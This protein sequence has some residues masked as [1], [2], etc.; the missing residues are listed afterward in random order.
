M[1]LWVVVKR[2][3]DG[4]EEV[5]SSEFRTSTHAREFAERQSVKELGTEFSVQRLV[6]E[7]SY[8]SQIVTST[9]EAG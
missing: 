3:R 7:I 5:V 2:N 1:S 8:S 9:C 4:W 6:H